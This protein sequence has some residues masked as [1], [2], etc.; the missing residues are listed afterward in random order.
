MDQIVDQTNVLLE[1]LLFAID[2]GELSAEHRAALKTSL[3]GFKRNHDARWHRM[4]AAEVKRRKR[5]Y[6]KMLALN[7]KR[8][9]LRQQL[10]MDG[11][12]EIARAAW[13]R[14]ELIPFVKATIHGHEPERSSDGCNEK[15]KEVEQLER[16]EELEDQDIRSLLNETADDYHKP[17]VRRYVVE[18]FRLILD[19]HLLGTRAQPFTK[20]VK[21]LFDWLGIEPKY[22]PTDTSIRAIV[23]KLKRDDLPNNRLRGIVRAKYKK[24]TKVERI[25]TW[26]VKASRRVI[27]K[28]RKIMTI[29]AWRTKAIER[30]IKRKTRL[31]KIGAWLLKHRP[32]QFSKVW[33]SA[34]GSGPKT[35]LRFSSTH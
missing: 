28:K 20:A 34:L 31:V 4:A 18:P 33:S 16:L 10:G 21:A 8:R 2:E 30:K 3:Q 9:K 25:L 17:R 26:R 13:I 29:S 23:R 24:S 22:R 32:D 7:A 35:S 5:L 1:R 12:L 15:L 27:N 19:G 11:K 14:T 6:R